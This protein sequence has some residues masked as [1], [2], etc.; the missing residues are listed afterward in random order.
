MEV[1]KI[2]LIVQGVKPSLDMQVLKY[3]VVY[4]KHMNTLLLAKTLKLYYSTRPVIN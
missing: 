2:P 3:K 1:T 4:I